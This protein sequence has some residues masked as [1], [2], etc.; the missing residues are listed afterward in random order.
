MINDEL[1]RT[2]N[3]GLPLGK[4]LLIS[5]ELIY[6]ELIHYDCKHSCHPKVFLEESMYN[7]SKKSKNNYWQNGQ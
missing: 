3:D 5:N 2:F 6:A 1:W 4:A 7:I